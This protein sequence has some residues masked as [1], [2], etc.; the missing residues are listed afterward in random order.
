VIAVDPIPEL[1][2]ARHWLIGED[3]RVM[4]CRGHYVDVSTGQPR[5]LAGRK[6][7]VYGPTYTTFL[8]FITALLATTD[9]DERSTV[10][11][12]PRLA[13][14]D[15]AAF[16]SPFVAVASHLRR[17]RLRRSSRI[18]KPDETATIVEVALSGTR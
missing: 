12:L 2:P 1:D 13:E 14:L 11:V 10:T 7:Y 4:H 9:L 16:T 6:A 5:V 18:D 3:G 8:V 15:R 17:A